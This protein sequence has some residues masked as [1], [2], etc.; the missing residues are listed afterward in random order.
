M[1]A[2]HN[3]ETIVLVSHDSVN[4]VMLLQFLGLP[5]AS[6]WCIEQVPCCVNEIDIENGL[7]RVLRLNETHHLET[8]TGHG[9]S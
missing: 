3:D 2:S 1:L 6:Y 9:A 7:S 5:L 4:R 8:I